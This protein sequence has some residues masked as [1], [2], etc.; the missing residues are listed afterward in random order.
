MSGSGRGCSIGKIGFISGSSAV[1][2]ASS[3][4]EGLS[5]E[6]PQDSRV[7]FEGLRWKSVW[8]IEAGMVGTGGR[9]AVE[10]VVSNALQGGMSVCSD[11]G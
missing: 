3:E 7:Q 4:E 11:G 9:E 8:D 1:V 2:F 5:S 10:M 6:R